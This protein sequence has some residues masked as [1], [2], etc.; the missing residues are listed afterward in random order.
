MVNTARGATSRAGQVPDLGRPP[1]IRRDTF[2]D[3]LAD[4]EDEVPQTPQRWVRFA[5][6]ATSTLI[7]RPVEHQERTRPLSASQVPSQKLDLMDNPVS[8]K[9]LYE[10]G[11]S[12]SLQVA[13]TEF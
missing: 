4:A 9:D 8:R 10:E 13:P 12:G 3:I 11:F 5:D 1:I 6:V 7:P 2:E